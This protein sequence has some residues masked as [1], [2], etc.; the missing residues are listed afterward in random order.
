MNGRNIR[1][2]HRC[3][4]LE[5]KMLGP[6]EVLSVGSNQ[7]YFKLQLPDSWNI[8]WVFNI[9]SLERYKGT[10]PKKQIIEIEADGDDWVMKSIIAS[11]PSDDNTKQHVFLVKWKDFTPEENTWETYGNVAD[12]SM[13]LLEEYYKKNPMVEKDGRF[14]G[15][16]GNKRKLLRKRMRIKRS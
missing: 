12:H 8:H 10:D 9:D 15:S 3:K 7:R 5:D 6:F 14:A 11:G 13:E 2:K 16:K 4:K 1:T